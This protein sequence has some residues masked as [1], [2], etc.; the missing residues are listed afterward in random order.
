MIDIEIKD[1][2]IEK[3][4]DECEKDIMLKIAEFEAD[5]IGG[6]E[7]SKRSRNL[8]KIITESLKEHDVI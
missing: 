2:I 6:W 7:H 3:S 1:L 4:E 8:K 5:L